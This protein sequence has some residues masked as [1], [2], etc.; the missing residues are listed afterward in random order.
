MNKYALLVGV[1][2]YDTLG[3]LSYA[4]QDAEAFGE[5]LQSQYGFLPKEV[6]IMTC[7][8]S[9]V[10]RAVYLYIEEALNL[11]AS[12]TDLDL[13]VFG[14]WG[15]GFHAEDSKLYLCASDTLRDKLMKSAIS[16]GLVKE[17]L[18]QAGAINTW[19]VLDCC[20]NIVDGRSVEGAV[21][22]SADADQLSELARD[23]KAAPR[24]GVG[25]IPTVAV[26]N[27]CR[28]GQRAY[29]WDQRQHGVF[30]AH[31]LDAMRTGERSVSH[32]VSSIAEQVALTAESLYRQKQ[33]PFTIIEGKG[34]IVIDSSTVTRRDAQKGTEEYHSCPECGF[35]NQ[36]GQTFRCLKC[37]REYLCK[38][39]YDSQKNMCNRC[40]SL[41]VEAVDGLPVVENEAKDSPFD[42]SART[43]QILMTFVEGGTFLMGSDFTSDRGPSHDVTVD[44]FYISTY[45]VTQDIYEKV[46][47]KNPSKFRGARHPVENISWF[48]AVRFANALSRRDRLEEVYVIDGEDVGCDWTK[49]GYRLPTEA[50]W[51][52]AAR[53][54]NKSTGYTF[55]GSNDPRSVAWYGDNS[56]Y[57][58]HPV[59][60]KR[61]NELGLHDMAGN[62]IEWCWDWFSMYGSEALA[63]P[64][65][66][67]RGM[68]RVV[69]GGDYRYDRQTLFPEN[70]FREE[71]STKEDWIGFRLVLQAK[72][73]TKNSAK[74]RDTLHVCPECRSFNYPLQT[75]RCVKCGRENLCQSHYD[76]QKGMCRRCASIS[77]I[78]TRKLR[79]D[80]KF[81]EGGTF[82][83]GSDDYTILTK[84]VHSVTLDSFYMATYEV[85]QDIYEKVMGTNPSFRNGVRRPVESLSWFDT[86]RFANALSLHD[87]LEEVYTIN[88]EN[89]SCDWAKR[90]YRLPTEAEWEYGARGGIMDR[91]RLYPEKKEEVAFDRLLHSSRYHATFFDAYEVGEFKSNELG[92]Y[93]MCGNVRE[94]CWDW[95]GGYSDATQMNP[96]GPESGMERIIRGGYMRDQ[97]HLAS[98]VDRSCESPS[99]NE[100]TIGFRLV[101]PA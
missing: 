34:D 94:W 57:K 18:T 50:E 66:P 33:E 35:Y 38:T 68:G 49:S 44:G 5:V 9:G 22:A 52:Y 16:L 10:S 83:M 55:P 32:I 39:H 27:S 43:L 54:G 26:I 3:R 100:Y 2:K 89:V 60:K 82:L 59:G 88:G 81:V 15:H 48:D 78:D 99:G 95:F 87:G 80:M 91:G 40:A 92:L 63:N 98:V 96:T 58:T 30:T 86:V 4:K 62:V 84:P 42:I 11:I 37:G 72:A 13:L 7:E 69:R 19:I 51:E 75:F 56:R 85:T 23:L 14:F 1:N 79:I 17:H 36:V 90:G 64:T 53:G 97:H 74:T 76:E 73:N 20:R 28:I 29:E 12:K 24:K 70:Y 67:A 65:G 6:Q 101:L 41:S 93:D 25:Q 61:P 71:P 31:L 8:S 21:F 46:M 45:E 77:I 47:K